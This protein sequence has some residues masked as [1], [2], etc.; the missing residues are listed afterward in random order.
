MLININFVC[1]DSEM[2]LNLGNHNSSK[3]NFYAGNEDHTG[4]VILNR[5]WAASV[6]LLHYT[7]WG[8][9]GKAAVEVH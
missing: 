3:T 9:S 7:I 1:Q 4:G 2:P 8:D 6:V 5:R